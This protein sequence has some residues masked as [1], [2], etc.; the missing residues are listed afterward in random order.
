MQWLVLVPSVVLETNFNFLQFRSEEATVQETQLFVVV[1]KS[2]V[3][4]DSQFPLLVYYTT[5]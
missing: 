3:D 4:D 2:I 1:N 5:K